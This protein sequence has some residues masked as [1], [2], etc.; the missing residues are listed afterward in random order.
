MHTY[1][2]TNKTLHD[3]NI[4]Q[5]LTITLTLNAI[6]MFSICVGTWYYSII[7]GLKESELDLS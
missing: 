7:R 2:I 3:T 5:I 4:S 1:N 6:L